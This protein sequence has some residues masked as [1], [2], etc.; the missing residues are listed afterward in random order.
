MNKKLIIIVSSVILLIGIGLTIYFVGSDD[1]AADSNN[2]QP[3]VSDDLTECEDSTKYSKRYCDAEGNVIKIEDYDTEDNLESYTKHKYDAK[4]NEIK[5]EDY[6]GDGN[7]EGYIQFEYDDEGNEIKTELYDAEGNLIDPPADNPVSVEPS[8]PPQ[9][10]PL[11]KH[12]M[13]NNQPIVIDESELVVCADRSNEP[14]GIKVYCDADG[15]RVKTENYFSGSLAWYDQKEFDADGNVVK[16]DIYD[17]EGNLE[18]YTT[19][20]Y[21]AEGNHIKTEQYDADGNLLD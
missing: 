10:T 19:F 6:D 1:K 14:V 21:D 4:G 11:A 18:R 9:A 15:N 17:A 12:L 16:R 3:I 5:I 2:S 8:T 20:E 13:N 7:L